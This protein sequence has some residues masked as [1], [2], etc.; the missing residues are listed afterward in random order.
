MSDD[1]FGKRRE[2]VS[3]EISAARTILEVAPYFHATVPKE[4]GRVW[5][6]DYISNDEIQAK[7][8]ENPSLGV[9]NIAVV[10]F[11][12]KPG[13]KLRE[14]AGRDFNAVVASHVLEH[15]P[16]PVGWLNELL[17]VLEPGCTLMLV[18]PDKRLTSDYYR[19]ETTF[20][21]LI[22]WA[23]H[24][25]ATPTPGQVLDFLA[26][27]VEDFG[28]WGTRPYENGMLFEQAKRPWPDE[29]V[30]NTGIWSL[31]TRGY[32]DIHA[33]VWSPESFYKAFTRV[34]KSGLLNVEVGQPI[35]NK[36]EFLV[37]LVKLGEPK[38]LNVPT[39]AQPIPLDGASVEHQLGILRHDMSFLIQQVDQL[40]RQREQ[41]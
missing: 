30:I 20:A 21:Q 16:N 7:A 26:G 1:I 37:K 25:P 36:N 19:N 40:K 14:C 10:D 22:D 41:D 24:A 13:S 5:Y 17:S 2:L 38:A 12:W 34:A 6:T 15:I 18:L 27:S 4:P 8:A 28:G 31:T 39:A 9:Q 32:I 11:V 33:T 29:E 23:I 3:C 35:Q